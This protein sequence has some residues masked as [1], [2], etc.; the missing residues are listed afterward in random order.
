MNVCTAADVG[1]TVPTDAPSSLTDTSSAVL[2]DRSAVAPL[3]VDSAGTGACSEQA[4]CRSWF[5]LADVHVD[6]IDAESVASQLWPWGLL[7]DLKAHREASGLGDD[8]PADR[9]SA[10]FEVVR[11]TV[12]LAALHARLAPLL[13]QLPG[14]ELPPPPTP[15]LPPPI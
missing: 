4:F 3:D 1:C 6:A 8:D 2:L 15:L 11:A 14:V 13:A 5:E 12:S 7:A 10:P 9:A